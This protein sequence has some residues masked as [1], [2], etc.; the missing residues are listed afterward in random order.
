LFGPV[1]GAIAFLL[2]EQVIGSWTTHWPVIFG[3]ILILIVLFAKRGLAGLFEG[4][5]LGGRT[6]GG[7]GGGHG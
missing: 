6:V 2:L 1:L 4:G 5:L 3:P 7:S